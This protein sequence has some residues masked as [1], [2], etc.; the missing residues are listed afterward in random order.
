V[1]KRHFQVRSAHSNEPRNGS[2]GIAQILREQ[3]IRRIAVIS[4]QGAGDDWANLN[5][6]FKALVRVSNIKAGFEDHT[7]VDRLLRASGTDWT[8]ARAVALTDRT[9][10]GP[11][12]AAASGTAKPGRWINRGRPRRFPPRRHRTRHL[13]RPSTAGMERLS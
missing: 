11:V 13:D 8:L 10:L 7:G 3:G 1:C 9:G 5:P 6:M 4:T 12:R 2:E